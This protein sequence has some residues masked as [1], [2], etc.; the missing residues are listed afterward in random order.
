MLQHFGP[1]DIKIA[2]LD[3]VGVIVLVY[4]YFYNHL[5]N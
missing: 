4:Y 5:K 1:L 3:S 2:F